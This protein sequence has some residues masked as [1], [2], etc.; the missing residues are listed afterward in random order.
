MV[1]WN[2][3]SLQLIFDLT[4]CQETQKTHPRNQIRLILHYGLCILTPVAR[5]SASHLYCKVKPES[6]A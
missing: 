2:T 6:I 1:L 3:D 4:H 5:R